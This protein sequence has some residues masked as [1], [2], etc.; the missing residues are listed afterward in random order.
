MTRHYY[1][2][3]SSGPDTNLQLYSL[4]Q[5]KLYWSALERDLADSDQ[6]EHFHERCVFIICTMG[7]SVS[8]LLGQNI[9][10]PSGRVPSPSNIFGSLIDKHKLDAHLKD[11]FREFVD[12]Y[13]QCRH[14]GLTNDGSRHWEVSQLTLDKTRKFY[15][16]GLVVWETIIGIFRKDPDNELE[17]LDLSGIEQEL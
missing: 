13:D 6:V 14:F 2:I 7:L 1:Y 12:T 10:E 8:Q 5:A 11:Q 15:S 4:Q 3:D 9:P 16:F 17:E